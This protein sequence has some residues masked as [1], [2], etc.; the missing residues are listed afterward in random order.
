MS[1]AG[2]VLVGLG[3]PA[4]GCCGLGPLFQTT[5]TGIEVRAAA[6]RAAAA[7]RFAVVLRIL[8]LLD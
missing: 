8:V 5:P 3:G 6:L 4:A 1:L 2:A 7:V